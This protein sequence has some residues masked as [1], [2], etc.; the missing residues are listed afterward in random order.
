MSEKI[1]V[2]LSLR[3]LILSIAQKVGLGPWVDMPTWLARES[4]PKEEMRIVE[5]NL[6]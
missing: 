4:C 2:Q 5:R 3:K 1:S 6:E